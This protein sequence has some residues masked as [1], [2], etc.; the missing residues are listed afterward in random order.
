[1]KILLVT[2]QTDEIRRA[3]D[4]G[5]VDAIVFPNTVG[6]GA[7][8]ADVE[9]LA[10]LSRTF[11]IPLHVSIAA[12][13]GSDI[14]RVAREL[15]RV[16]DRENVIVQVPLVEDAIAPI[17]KLC[18][19]GIFVCATYVY[20]P[21]QALIAAKAGAT[22]IMVGLSDLNGQGTSGIEI[23]SMIRGVLDAADAWMPPTQSVMCWRIRR[24]HRQTSW[25][26]SWRA[27]KGS[28]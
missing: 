8:T 17:H 5:I 1:M 24:R 28:A 25:T 23:V 7:E 16:L 15:H 27:L 2:D 26:A 9:H 18:I 11:A 14:Y 20:S 6:N 12:V 4:A 22:S 19:D 21:T 3:T 13:A 10:D